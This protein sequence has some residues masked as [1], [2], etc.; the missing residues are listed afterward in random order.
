MGL[1]RNLFGGKPRKTVQDD[2]FGEMVLFRPQG[3]ASVWAGKWDLGEDNLEFF[4]AGDEQAPAEDALQLLEKLVA[5][6][7]LLD[8]AKAA[9]IE[10]LR[11]ADEGYAPERF[12]TDMA[13]SAMSIKTAGMFEITFVQRHDPYYHFNVDFEEGRIA[14]VS[15]DS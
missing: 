10:T 15:I 1:L 5:E 2:R 11:N 4:L 7:D 14:G 8:Q 13:L 6:P 9:V 12:E 3:N